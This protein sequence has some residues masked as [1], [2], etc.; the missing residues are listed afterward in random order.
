MIEPLAFNFL[1]RSLLLSLSFCARVH[2]RGLGHDQ[3]QGAG[4]LTPQEQILESKEK[5][6][7]SPESGSGSTG[8]LPGRF[9]G[10]GKGLRK[11]LWRFYGMESGNQNGD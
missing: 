6:S 4:V 1:E 9:W 2:G 7:L 8:T 5:R 10:M 3:V 11:R